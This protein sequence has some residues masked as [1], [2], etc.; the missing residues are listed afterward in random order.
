MLFI[1]NAKAATGQGL[2]D[3][4]EYDLQALFDAAV[5]EE[6][7]QEAGQ[8]ATFMELLEGGLDGI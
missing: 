5:L 4:E 7:G 2:L 1:A 6:A 3:A 8:D